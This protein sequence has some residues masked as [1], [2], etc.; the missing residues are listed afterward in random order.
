MCTAVIKLLYTVTL[1]P[2]YYNV[3]SAPMKGVWSLIERFE[4]MMKK[5]KKNCKNF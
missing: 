5:T 2:T 4:N 3:K 1:D